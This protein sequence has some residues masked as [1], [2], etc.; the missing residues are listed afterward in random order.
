MGVGGVGVG[1]E[2][3]VLGKEMSVKRVVVEEGWG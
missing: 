1:Y 2:E 3:G